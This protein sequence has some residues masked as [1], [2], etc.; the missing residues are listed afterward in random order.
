MGPY[1]VSTYDNYKYF[2]TLVDDYSR[3]TWTHLLSTKSNALQVLKKF[4]VMIENQFNTTLKNI[5]T[6][7]GLEFNNNETHQFLLSKGIVHQKT[8]PYTPQ[9]NSVVERKHKYLLET[10]RALLFQSKLPIRYWG[11][12]FLTA[13][14]IINRLPSS[15]LR[16]KCPYE[17]LYNKKP[18]YSHLRSF[19]CLCYPTVPKVLRDK[20]EPRTT[21]HV[22]LGYVFGTKGYKVMNLAT[23]KLHITR[24]VIFHEHV[25]PFTLS[26]ESSSFP[27]VLKSFSSPVDT[28]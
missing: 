7:N 5:R 4:I 1:H 22:F 17:V 3:S 21:P 24:D 8:C 26:T 19:G 11:E 15:Y 25:F 13:T 6:D 10:A 28:V 23:K 27:S 20:F 2:I 9:Q 12:C 14:H 18:S 16:N